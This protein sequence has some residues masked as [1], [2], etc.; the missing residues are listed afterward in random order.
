LLEVLLP[1][2]VVLDVLLLELL[3]AFD[4]GERDT[5]HLRHMQKRDEE[6]R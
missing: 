3:T 4:C 5:Q 1:Q 6:V 2:E